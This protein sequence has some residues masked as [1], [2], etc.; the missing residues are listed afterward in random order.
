MIS[1]LATLLCLVLFT[2]I[3]WWFARPVALVASMVVGQ[4]G[5]I[6]GL[7]VLR[8]GGSPAF[9]G[10]WIAAVG[11]AMILVI[12]PQT[13]G[14]MS[15]V[16]PWLVLLPLVAQLFAGSRQGWVWLVVA[17]AAAAGLYLLSGVE[18][19][20]FT[21]EQ[22]QALWILSV[23]SLATV[24]YVIFLL[25]NSLQI[26]L[27]DRLEEGSDYVR[28]VLQAVP[29]GVLSLSE[30]G[31]VKAANRAAQAMFQRS[32]QALL[33]MTIA[34]LIP[35]LKLEAVAGEASLDA[36]EMSPRADHL[37]CRADG[38]TFPLAISIDE[39][40]RNGGHEPVLALR[41]ETEIRQ[42]RARMMET[43]RMSAVGTLVLGVA[44]EINNPLAY[45]KGNMEFVYARLR[46]RLEE[47]SEMSAED[48][49]LLDAMEDGLHG[50]NRIEELVSDLR[51]FSSP[52]D[53]AKL[54]NVHEVLGS[55]IALAENQFRNRARLVKDFEDVPEVLGHSSGLGQVFMNLLV[56]AAQAIEE[57]APEDNQIEVATKVDEGQVVVTVSD[58]GEGIDDDDLVRIFDPFFTT[59]DPHQGTG[60][61]LAISRNI[62][63][64]MG[65]T[66]SATSEKGEGTRIE[67]RLPV[68]P[69]KSVV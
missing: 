46:D 67:V 64:E 13:G 32:E 20:Y 4:V 49:S 54:T 24:G 39:V 45:S 60:L 35:G 17:A 58:T 34:E 11:C 18:S 28:T 7:V 36:G 2:G 52:G 62:I 30:D 31:V 40:R 19:P 22:L 50:L 5:I 3:Y 12:A 42:M 55:A 21:I 51:V 23:V 69:A 48:R 9:V 33:G 43:D 53:E 63:S 16:T 41:D 27:K 25:A 38:E 8:H 26:W 68:A 57:G 61:G 66:I 47:D 59:K 1:T 56:N 44:H 15:P 29:T 14:I 65:G 37:G 6:A 10:N